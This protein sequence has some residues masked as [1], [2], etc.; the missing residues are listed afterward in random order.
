LPLHKSWRSHIVP[1]LTIKIQLCLY[2]EDYH[3]YS[4]FAVIIASPKLI[5]PES[6]LTTIWQTI[7][8]VNPTV[9]KKMLWKWK[10]RSTHCSTSFP[11]I[12]LHPSYHSMLFCLNYWQHWYIDHNYMK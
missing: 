5:N 2:W 9:K 10:G 4:F 8:L 11:F 6:P 3:W 7:L 12:D 1:E